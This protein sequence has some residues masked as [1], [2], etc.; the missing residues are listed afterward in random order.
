VEV[1][2][3]V[4][5]SPVPFIAAERWFLGREVRT[6]SS[7]TFNGGSTDRSKGAAGDGT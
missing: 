2:G 7:C 3:R 5:E 6:R 4:G 1:R